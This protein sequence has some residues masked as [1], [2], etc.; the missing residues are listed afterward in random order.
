MGGKGY[1]VRFIRNKS[2][3]QT[4]LNLTKI[5]NIEASLVAQMVKNPPA[6]WETWV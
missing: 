2:V 6:M 5:L 3:E 4:L 1:L